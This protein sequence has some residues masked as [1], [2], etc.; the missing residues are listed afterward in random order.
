[1]FGGGNQHVAAVDGRVPVLP[2]AL[3]GQPQ[4]LSELLV[5]P[6]GPFLSRPGWTLDGGG[7]GDRRLGADS[8]SAKNPPPDTT[9]VKRNR[10]KQMGGVSRRMAHLGREADCPP[11]EKVAVGARALC[12]Q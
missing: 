5:V 10:L 12:T 9:G 6:G 7:S 1:M 3:P 4:Q 8:L 11:H 2:G